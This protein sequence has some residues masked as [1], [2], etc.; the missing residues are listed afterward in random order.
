MP[1]RALLISYAY[2]PITAPGAIRVSKFARYLP[3]HDWSPTVLTVDG[4]YSL[5]KSGEATNIPGVEVERV[6]DKAYK[7]AAAQAASGGGMKGKG[8]K[9]AVKRFARNL[10]IPDRDSTW[11][12]PARVK[13]LELARGM[14]A[15]YSSSPA[16]SNHEVARAVAERHGLPWVADFRDPWTMG[17]QYEAPAW[18]HGID[19]KIEGRIMDLAG[20]VL[21][22]SQNIA[23]LVRAAYPQHAK[24]VH[25]V[26]NGFDPS[27]FE[28]LPAASKDKFILS[29]AGSFYGGQRSPRPILKAMRRLWDAKVIDPDRFALR[30]IG[31]P[32]PTIEAMIAE[33]GVGGLVEAVGLKPYP[34]TLKLL[35]ESSA[36]LVITFPDPKSKGEL[37]TKFFDYLALQRPILAVAPDD[38]ELA[39][40]LLDFKAGGVVGPTDADAA[41]R[42]ISEAVSKHFAEGPQT[43]DP[44]DIGSLS[45]QSATKQLAEIFSSL[46]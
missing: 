1:R 20:A 9:G 12:K 46:S 40:M 15:V 2:P 43:L 31:R 44:G 35:S 23:A 42:W 4:G 6:A 37:T 26:Y 32:E 17:P 10:F 36:L 25:V 38:F 14:D 22:V 33:E 41:E 19:R 3:D 13:A 34:E 21:V 30:L 18:R 27:D 29:Y 45:R 5:M 16:I 39:Q 24:K 7:T 28:G 11:I 8:I